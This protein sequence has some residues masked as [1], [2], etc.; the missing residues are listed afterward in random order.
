MALS[1]VANLVLEAEPPRETPNTSPALSAG[2]FTPNICF[3]R[4]LGVRDKP[5]P[6]EKLIELLLVL[7]DRLG[8]R[9]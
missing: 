9:D 6:P 1:S 3:V 2:T 7:A 5:L 4:M 8:C